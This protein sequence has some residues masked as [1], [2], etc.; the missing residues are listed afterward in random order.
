MFYTLFNKIGIR[1]APDKS[2][3]IFSNEKQNVESS[4]CVIWWCF[5]KH[6]IR[7]EISKYMSVIS[8]VHVEVLVLLLPW[9]LE[10]TT[11]KIYM[12]YLIFLIF[13]H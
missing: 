13:F 7:F 9:E 1:E 10:K 4:L 6:F 8:V 12:T 5:H 11:H 3:L 2:L